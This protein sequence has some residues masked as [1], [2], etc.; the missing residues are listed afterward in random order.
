MAAGVSA[1]G[2]HHGGAGEACARLLQAAVKGVP[3]DANMDALAQALV[4][5]AR[6]DGLRLPGFGHRIHDPD[7]RAVY[8]LELATELELAGPHAELATAIVRALR[9]E[10]GR[11]LPLNVDGALAGC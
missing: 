6:V 2:E 7:P 3:A 10:T 4:Q 1:I 9:V 11:S 8:L 5:A